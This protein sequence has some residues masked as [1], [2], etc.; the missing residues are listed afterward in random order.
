MAHL[1]KSES[2]AKQKDTQL[3]IPFSGTVFHVLPQVL[4]RFEFKLKTQHR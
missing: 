2:D 3:L 1:S 4:F